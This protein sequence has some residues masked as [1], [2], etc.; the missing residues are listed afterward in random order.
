MSY[1]LNNEQKLN[2]I[3]FAHRNK[4]YGAYVLRSDYGF[5]I[6]KSLAMVAAGVAS[7]AFIAYLFTR[8]VP[9]IDISDQVI[10]DD[11]IVVPFTKKPEEVI[12]KTKTTTPPSTPPPPPETKNP[13][14]NG[15]PLVVDTTAKDNSTAVVNNTVALSL[16]NV[17]TSIAGNNPDPKP[18]NVISDDPDVDKTGVANTFGL[19][20]EAEFEGGLAALYKF[21]RDNS[22]YP[23]EAFAAG[24]E[25]TMYVK[26]VVDENGKVSRLTLLNTRG[27]GLDEEALRVV[28][29]LPK[30][31]SPAKMKGR[32]VKSY[33]QVPIKFRISH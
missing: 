3:I 16:S 9:V 2:E 25:G 24:V 21:I 29:M 28:G 4:A 22:R 33:Y 23:E 30:F 5:T 12:P 1:H 26:F 20:K 18:D 19:E 14:Q 6:A 27:Y 8:T 31:K 32:A 10:P 15:A 17:T 7:L 13:N 11:V